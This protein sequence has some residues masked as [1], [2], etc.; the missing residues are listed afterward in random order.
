MADI[1]TLEGTHGTTVSRALSIEANGFKTCEGRLGTGAY[2]WSGSPYAEYLAKSW[3]DFDK[4]RK[5]YWKDENKKCAIIWAHFI[6]EE[7]R[8]LDLDDKEI[9]N[10]LAELCLRKGIGFS[11]RDRELA[12]TIMRFVSGIEEKLGIKFKIMESTISTAPKE[13]VTKYPLSVL[14]SPSCYIVL[15]TTCIKIIRI[16]C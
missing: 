7:D 11:V 12:A 14:G 3:W 2:F 16:D 6:V 15:D 4:Y 13:F 8:F 9:K 5:K 1:I 10:S